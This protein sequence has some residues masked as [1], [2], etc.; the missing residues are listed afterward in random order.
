MH[1]QL[2]EIIQDTFFFITEYILSI[3][4]YFLLPYTDLDFTRNSL[5]P[6]S[7]NQY[8]TLWLQFLILGTHFLRNP[9]LAKVSF[10][11]ILEI[12]WPP[13]SF[14]SSSSFYCMGTI[15]LADIISISHVHSCHIAWK[16]PTMDGSN[17]PPS[18]VCACSN[19]NAAEEKSPMAQSAF[20]L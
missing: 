13:S 1:W 15:S 19:L 14:S 6:K 12:H 9:R 18:H 7:P 2:K 20:I 17:H 11:L 3:S 4:A 8:Y 10:S 16:I 5:P